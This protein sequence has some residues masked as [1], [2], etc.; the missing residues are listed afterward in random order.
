M[1]PPKSSL[2]IAEKKF[3]FFQLG[4]ILDKQINTTARRKADFGVLEEEYNPGHN[5]LEFCNILLWLR[6]ARIK[7]KL[8]IKYSKFGVGVTARVP[9]LFKLRISGN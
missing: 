1:F 9:N 8:D 5:F 4:G 7:A 6:F 2:V 3:G